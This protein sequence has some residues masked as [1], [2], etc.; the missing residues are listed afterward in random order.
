[1]SA[2]CETQTPT[3]LWGGTDGILLSLCKDSNEWQSQLLLFAAA[4]PQCFCS[5]ELATDYNIVSYARK[6]LC[7]LPRKNIVLRHALTKWSERNPNELN[8]VKYGK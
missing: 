6:L 3:C 8:A 7:Q 4:L 5:S 1:M 2:L